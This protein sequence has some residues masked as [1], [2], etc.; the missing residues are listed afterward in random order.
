MLLYD[1]RCI[2]DFFVVVVEGILVIV[3]IGVATG[4]VIGGFILCLIN[5][6][7]KRYKMMSGIFDVK[8]SRCIL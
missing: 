1:C 3:M 5:I 4:I 6:V 8:I 7:T 2:T